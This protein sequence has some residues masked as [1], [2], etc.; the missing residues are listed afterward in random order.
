MMHDCKPLFSC[1][2]TRFGGR[3]RIH[4][5]TLIEL[6]IV[7]AIIAIL[8]SMLLPALNQARES[9]RSSQC[10]NNLRQTSTFMQ[11]YAL[12]NNHLAIA[13]RGT[14]TPWITMLYEGKYV[15]SRTDKL[16]Y[17]PFLP[18]DTSNSNL[19]LQ[20]FGTLWMRWDDEE[21][22]WDKYGHG[23]FRT[24]DQ[25]NFNQ[26]NNAMCYVTTRVRNP[27]TMPHFADT[28][29][30]SGAKPFHGTANLQMYSS[31]TEFLSLHHQNTANVTFFDGHAS[32]TTLNRLAELGVRFVATAEE[33]RVQL[34]F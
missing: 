18:Y 34:I 32:R 24:F 33:V 4:L 15:K 3:G 10:L 16:C 27:S 12:D 22:H 14:G 25:S 30:I 1:T 17:C 5:F 7:I 21:K 26:P 8:A 23:K 28:K 19:H 11:L 9:A 31:S 13:A 29:V 6:L 20:T 2:T